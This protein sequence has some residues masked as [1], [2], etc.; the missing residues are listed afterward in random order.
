MNEF[1]LKK[2]EFDK[3]K[4]KLINECSSGLGKEVAQ[5]IEPITDLE[6]IQVWQQET[7]EGVLIRRFEPQIPLGG[8]VDIRL[9]IR[10]AEIGGILEAEEFLKVFDILSASRK[11]KKF[12]VNNKKQYS[13]PRM[14]LL[15][16]RLNI[17]KDLEDE[18]EKVI[19]P[20]GEVRDTASSTL[21]T[22]RRKIVT[23]Q[24]RIKEKLDNFVKSEHS[25]KFLQDSIITIRGDRYV[26]PVKQECRNQVP[27][28]I[29]DQSGSGATLFIEPMAIVELNNDLRKTHSEERDEILRIL[30]E[31]SAK[32]AQ[33]TEDL[34]IN[35]D[36]LSKIDFIFAKARLSEKLDCTEPKIVLERK[37]TINRGR[38][39]LILPNEVVPLTIS[40]G[41]D[42][43]LLVITGPNT[44]GK[45]VTLKTVG[46]F[47][48]I[49]QSG[50]HIPADI[51]S[52]I[53]IFKK[54]FADIGDEQSIEQSLSTF[55]SH[56]TN[57]VKILEEADDFTL[58][59]LDELGAGTDPSEGAALAISI[60]EYLKAKNARLIATTHYSELKTYAFNE[61]MVQN[62]S[63]EF[64]IKTL[65]PTYKLLIGVP[66]K[67]NAFEIASRLGLKDEIVLKARSLISQDEKDV[68][69]LIESLES[70]RLTSE[71]SKQQ[72]E[73]K[74][75][76]IEEKLVSIKQQETKINAS[77]EKIIRKAEEE[78]LQ[79]VKNARKES[80]N[81]IKEIRQ[82]AK[83]EIIKAEYKALELKKELENKEDKLTSKILKGPK[84][85]G[86]K[87]KNLKIGQEV[88]IPKLNQAGTVITEP[89]NNEELQ[90]Q[91]GILKIIV[92]LDEVQIVERKKEITQ[93]GIGKI[94]SNKS[95]SMKNE[96]DFRG[97]NVEE[98]IP[99]V[100]KYLDDAYLTGLSQV[101]L[102][103]GKGTGVLRNSIREMLK[104]HPHVK[105]M[106]TGGF[107]EGGTGVTVVELKK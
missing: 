70:N 66:G 15:G 37:I 80:E 92:K 19:S 18:I 1:T 63:V 98:A 81:I 27:G 17:I 71:L 21:L 34:K 73:N 51:G 97:T 32:M 62:A 100:D 57:I 78:A 86:Q 90:V 84:V 44:G 49:A 77:S 59:L 12:F 50:L 26:V 41:E 67:S 4:T 72:A 29:H 103:H 28:I 58:I 53:G 96:F 79:I 39:P 74:L 16:G 82:L 40:L 68:A 11:L 61:P 8:I 105:A 5:T 60:L 52:S 102:I 48:L 93:R 54:V 2:L 87:P 23:L 85:I 42:F 46:L 38:H 95:E 64:D 76:L 56:M 99:L 6:L 107:D 106:R 22:L 10:K 69:D 35:L 91:A 14:E 55:S 94:V 3:I 47:V 88:F 65:R 83:E 13:C 7:T 9:Q 75:K 36:I 104:R 89:N 25:N 101:Y 33:Y 20:E 45:T 24:N 30:S 43:G 31:L